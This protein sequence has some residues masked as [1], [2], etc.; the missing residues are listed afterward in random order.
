MIRIDVWDVKTFKCFFD[1]V[2]DTDTLQL[3]FNKEGLSISLLDK[4]HICFYNIEY[5]VAFFDEYSVDEPV[6][7]LVDANEFNNILKSS[8]NET[9]ALEID[10]YITF[11]FTNVKSNFERRI[12]ITP[13][14]QEYNPSIP[15]RVDNPCDVKVSFD[16]LKT[17][18]NDIDNLCGMDRCKFIVDNDGEFHITVVNSLGVDYDVI[19]YDAD[20]TGDICNSI[21]SLEYLVTLCKFQDI[22]KNIQ[23]SLGDT[24][25]LKWIITSSDCLVVCT[26]LLAPR[27]EQ[28]D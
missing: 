9:V 22:D 4:S 1:A 15:P 6:E 8:K 23:L 10:E 3:M 25:P 2:A 5:D 13:V 28:E 17:A 24:V 18:F 14:D 19:C 20:V 11:I 7:V 26:G 16:T 21:F 12:K 27:I